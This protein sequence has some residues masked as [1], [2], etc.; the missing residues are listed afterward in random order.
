MAAV[1]REKAP[2]AELFAVRIFTDRLIVRRDAGPG[3]GLGG[4][5]P[6]TPGQSEP[7]HHRP[8][9]EAALRGALHRAAASGVSVVVAV[10]IALIG[11]RIRSNTSFV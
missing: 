5:L 8:E 1:I 3:P 7:R 6:H 2:D 11:E 9:H 4:A 10:E